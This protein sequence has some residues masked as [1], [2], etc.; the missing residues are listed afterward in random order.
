MGTDIAN[1]V[2]LHPDIVES[3]VLDGD[4]SQLNAG[5]RVAY[6]VH[7]C[8]ALGIDPGEQPFDLISLNGKLKLYATKTCANALTRVNRL[9][10]E[11]KSTKFDGSL[12]IVEARAVAPDG[13]FADDMGVLDLDDRDHKRLGKPNAIMKAATKAK[14]RAVLALVGL[15]VLDVSEVDD[16]RS[17]D[18]M[19]LDVASGTIE[20]G[21]I[22]TTAEP[23]DIGPRCTGKAAGLAKS[24]AE[25]VG[26]LAARHE[27]PWTKAFVGVLRRA[28][29]DPHKYGG[30][31]KSAA[32]LTV[33]DGQKAREWLLLALEPADGPTESPGDPPPDGTVDNSAQAWV[34]GEWSSLV[35]SGY[36]EPEDQS[37]AFTRW[38]GVDPWPR[39]PSDD[40]WA[41]C[42]E[43]LRGELAH[44][45]E[46]A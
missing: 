21:C 38:S 29:I 12:V 23:V 39:R 42:A 36:Y 2:A 35:A 46:G 5:Q 33:E 31:I 34:L 1:V 19:R 7:R 15:G 10:I 27:I 43:G 37:L 40:D 18:R 41:A 14:R 28:E 9:S 25:K 4:L 45:D 24:V 44:L 16:I 3:L 26:E 6:Y 30:P 22:T 8:N 20:A 11:I 32:E 13:R 17:A